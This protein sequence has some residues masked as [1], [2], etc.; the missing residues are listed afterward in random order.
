MSKKIEKLKEIN[1]RL[2]IM[3]SMLE[4]H[5]FIKNYDNANESIINEKQMSNNLKQ[6]HN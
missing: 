5:M 1:T 4:T 3:I 6:T 2:N